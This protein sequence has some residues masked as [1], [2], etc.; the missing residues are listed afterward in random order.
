MITIILTDLEARKLRDFLEKR[1][2]KDA[3]LGRVH[4]KV[5][6]ALLRPAVKRKYAN[7]KIVVNIGDDD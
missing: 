3:D 7:T 1:G 6:H 4:H 2:N 5:H